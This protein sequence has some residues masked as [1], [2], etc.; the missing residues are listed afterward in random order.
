MNGIEIYNNI[1]SLKASHFKSIYK[2]F[3]YGH[4]YSYLGTILISRAFIRTLCI[5]NLFHFLRAHFM[6]TLLIL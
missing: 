2:H 3:F 4:K 5:G 1:T 6:S